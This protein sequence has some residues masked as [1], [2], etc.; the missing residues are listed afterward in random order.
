MAW[1]SIAAPSRISAQYVKSVYRSRYETGR[2][3]SRAASTK[4]RRKW[5]LSWTAMTQ[6]DL[7]DL[8][9]AFEADTGGTFSWTHPLTSESFTVGYASDQVNFDIS[10]E[11]VN[12]YEVSVSLQ[13]Q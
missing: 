6:S 9:A 4:G 13:E 2:P 5:D 12:R 10:G 7:D 11:R 3:L 8:I 1:P